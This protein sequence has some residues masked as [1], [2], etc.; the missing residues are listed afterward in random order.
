[1]ISAVA[2]GAVKCCNELCDQP[3]LEGVCSKLGKSKQACSKKCFKA[4]EAR[5]EARRS[6]Q[7]QS[8]KQASSGKEEEEVGSSEDSTIPSSSTSE[9]GSEDEDKWCCN[10]RFRIEGGGREWRKCL[11]FNDKSVIECQRCS[12][13][14]YDRDEEEVSAPHST[15]EEPEDNKGQQLPAT[16]MVE[17]FIDGAAELM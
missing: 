1:M 15:T 4:Q 9:T 10:R 16:V 17:H 13:P 11:M 3:R 2:A 6:S 14:R 8:K 5:M 12:M 7:Q